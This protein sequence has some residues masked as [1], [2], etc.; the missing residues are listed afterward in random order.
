MTAHKFVCFFKI[1]KRFL[2]SASWRT[3]L[4]WKPNMRS[5]GLCLLFEPN[6]IPNRAESFMLELKGSG[7]ILDLHSLR[8]LSGAWE[9]W[10]LKGSQAIFQSSIRL[11]AEDSYAMTK[12][13]QRSSNWS[14]KPRR[15]F[16]SFMRLHVQGSSSK[17]NAQKGSKLE[18]RGLAPALNLDS[19]VWKKN[20]PQ[21]VKNELPNEI[22][23]CHHLPLFKAN[24]LFYSISET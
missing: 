1:K 11:K 15:A 10:F 18:K 3:R 21:I 22:Y 24:A 23:R 4:T 6:K 20:S 5:L 2:S 8:K 12:W 13:L 7:S 16:P 14:L 17:S 9:V 19:T